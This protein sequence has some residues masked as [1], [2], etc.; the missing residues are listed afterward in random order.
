MKQSLNAYHQK[1]EALAGVQ[2]SIVSIIKGE[3]LIDIDEGYRVRN[4]RAVSHDNAVIQ[5]SNAMEVD[6]SFDNPLE[7]SESRGASNE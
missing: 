2:G 6:T 5:K 4:L 1:A 7:G 3:R